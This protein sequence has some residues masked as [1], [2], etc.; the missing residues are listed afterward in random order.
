[1]QVSCKDGYEEEAAVS[2]KHLTSLLVSALVVKSYA[3]SAKHRSTSVLYKRIV[4]FIC[5]SSSRRSI[6]MRSC[7]IGGTRQLEGGR[8]RGPTYQ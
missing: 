1:M 3:Q 6:F 2:G 5:F 8:Q 4:S 7:S